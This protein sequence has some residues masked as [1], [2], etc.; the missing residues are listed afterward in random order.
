MKRGLPIGGYDILYIDIR[1]S[2][3]LAYQNVLYLQNV[4][5]NAVGHSCYIQIWAVCSQKDKEFLNSKTHIFT[6]TQWK[7]KHS[8]HFW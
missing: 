6:K 1:N 4:V 7:T 8:Y 2:P 5:C 3:I